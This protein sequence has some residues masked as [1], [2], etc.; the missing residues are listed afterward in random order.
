MATSY[1]EAARDENRYKNKNDDCK[2]GNVKP[3]FL[4]ET[5]VF[6]EHDMNHLGQ[7]PFLLN[8]EVYRAIEEQVPVR[9]LIGLQRVRGIWR[10]Y[11]DN[12][13]DKKELLSLRLT[14]RR[15][16]ITLYLSFPKVTMNEE[17]N[18][19]KVRVKN[20]PLSADD[21][22]IL[23]TLETSVS[24]CEIITH[25]R[26]RLR[27][28]N[29]V[30]NCRTGDRIV[31]CKPFDPPLP[32]SMKIGNYWATISHFGQAS[33]SRPNMKCSKC[34]DEGHTA[35]NC[36]NGW[37]CKKC[38]QL[39]HRQYECEE[40]SD[41][42]VEE[43]GNTY[44][45][46]MESVCNPDIF[47]ESENDVQTN[48]QTEDND[49]SFQDSDVDSKCTTKP[50]LNTKGRSRS[51]SDTE[52]SHLNLGTQESKSAGKD[53][54]QQHKEKHKINKS[55]DRRPGISRYLTTRPSHDQSDTTN[56]TPKQSKTKNIE[57][58]PVTPT[59]NLHDATR[60]EAAKKPKK[61]R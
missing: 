44:M 46:N 8:I 52:H 41:V 61:R 43:E 12:E 47:H 42:E 26:E 13:Q 60:D 28:D 21:D 37:K 48:Q 17:P 22:Q 10:I 4:L 34:L 29:L 25:S 16:S 7:R 31:I 51:E 5:D 11:F 2:I 24:K 36:P 14:I 58:S 55:V 49:E 1:A 6:G 30:T 54:S 57:K 40:H 56:S 19:I 18:A 27:I 32:R 3:I 20:V 50:L 39:G 9:A 15:K 35:N 33:T 53:N 45:T 23:R 38:G 59:E